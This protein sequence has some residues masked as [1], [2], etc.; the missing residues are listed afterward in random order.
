MSDF[1][2][3]RE[4]GCRANE[5]FMSSFWVIEGITSDYSVLEKAFSKC[6]PSSSLTDKSIRRRGG[7]LKVSVFA[8]SPSRNLR[9]L[10]M[11]VGC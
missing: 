8:S 1:Q 10:P 6:I 2:V 4:P 11:S 9:I 7:G 3:P 5:D